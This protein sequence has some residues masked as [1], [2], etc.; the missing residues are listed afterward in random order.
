MALDFLAGCVGGCAGVIVGHPFDTIKVN[1]QTQD[2]KKPIYKGTWHCFTTIL[3]RDKLSGLYKGIS[4][5]LGGVA[6]VNAIIFGTHAKVS[7]WIGSE[8]L[9]S[10]F[11]AGASAGFFQSFIC[12]PLELCKTILQV[13]KNGVYSGA[14][15]CFAK[16]YKAQGLPGIYKGFFM[17]ICREVPS[18]GAYFM[19]FELLSGGWDAPTWRTMLAGGTAGSISWVIVYP[20]D[21]LKTRMQS[22]GINSKNKYNSYIHCFQDSLKTEG[23]MFL[24]RGIVSTIIRAFPTNAVTFTVVTWTM[25]LSDF[26]VTNSSLACVLTIVYINEF[27]NM[28]CHC[29]YLCFIYFNKVVRHQG[30]IGVWWNRLGL[31]ISILLH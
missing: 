4:S 31:N 7:R 21:V 6:L 20:V 16:I 1:L 2:F 17:T 28:Q 15:D 3:K 29:K 19:F 26:F 22:D 14:L 5:P 11:I 30:T 13:Q 8:G 25:R 18:F 24:T 27:R 9:H 10:H 23:Y 12:S